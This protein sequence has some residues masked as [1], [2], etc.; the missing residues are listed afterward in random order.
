MEL[1]LIRHGKTSENIKGVYLGSTNPSLDEIGVAEAIEIKK[2]MQNLNLDNI[3]VSP[4]KRCKETAKIIF[5]DYKLEELD[6]LKE[7]D[8]GL[9]EGKFY[10]EISEKYKI[11]FDSFIKDYKEF[12]FPNGEN[13]KSFYTRVKNSILNIKK[14][15]FNRVAIVAHEGTLR[16]ILCELLGIGIDGFYKIKLQHGCFSKINVFEDDCQLEYLNR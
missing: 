4:L 15:G 5:E 14:S 7:I 12:T 11:E 9:W 16:V 13:F 2:K 1:Y 10:R 8:F 6:E 3:Y